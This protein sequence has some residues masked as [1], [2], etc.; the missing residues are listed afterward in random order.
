MSFRV[1]FCSCVFSP[2]GIAVTSLGEERSNLSAFRTL[3]LFGLVGFLFLLG[4][5]KG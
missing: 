4:S 1:S 3:C 2:F 5:G